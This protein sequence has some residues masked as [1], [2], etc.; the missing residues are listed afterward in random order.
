MGLLTTA[1]L[2]S[3]VVSSLMSR[4]QGFS[5]PAV[6]CMLVSLQNTHAERIPKENEGE[7][8]G[9]YGLHMKCPLRLKSLSTCSPACSNIWERVGSLG[10]AILVEEVCHSGEGRE[11]LEVLQPKAFSYR[12]SMGL[13]PWEAVSP[14]CHH[15]FAALTVP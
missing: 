2:P 15:V 9:R 7:P 5:E 3:S 13:T 10:D 1:S 6:V 12:Y 4:L 11:E 8:T 14:S